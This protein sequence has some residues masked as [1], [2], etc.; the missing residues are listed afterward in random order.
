MYKK[1]PKQCPQSKGVPSKMKKCEVDLRGL[2]TVLAGW[3][4]EPVL[5]L[6]KEILPCRKSDTGRYQRV[7]INN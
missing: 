4:P 3:A 1:M 5:T 6:D 2:G 7:V